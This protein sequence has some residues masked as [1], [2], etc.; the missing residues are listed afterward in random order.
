MSDDRTFLFGIGAAKAG[1][2]WLFNYLFTHP[3]CHFRALK[4]LHY[5]NVL[6]GKGTDWPRR[7]R[8]RRLLGIERQLTDPTLQ[9]N[10][11][12]LE[13]LKADIISWNDLFDGKTQDDVGYANF[14]TEGSK[15]AAVVGE[16]TPAYSTLDE[17]GFA[18]M[19][20]IGSRSKFIML[21]RDP[22]DRMWS[23]VRMTAQRNASRLGENP[24]KSAVHQVETFISGENGDLW[25]RSDYRGT[26]RRLLNAVPHDAVL[27]QFFE[28]LFTPGALRRITGFL[29]I[30]THHGDT[31]AVR[32]KG[33]KM[34]MS[35]DLRRRALAALAPQYEFI[36]SMFGDNMPATWRKNREQL[37][38]AGY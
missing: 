32:N 33:R 3:E 28:Q 18:H 29:G 1:T 22:L 27:F 9:V 20:S 6:H 10:K 37:F 15:D 14:L 4:E 5:F 24:R 16:V 30:S 11:A 26:I 19:A 34:Q 7:S 36:S 21:L 8:Q 35:N 25:R 12:R 38:L 23:N 2:S 31:Q 17:T 13:Q